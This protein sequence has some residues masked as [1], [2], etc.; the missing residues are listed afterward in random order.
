MILTSTEGQT[1]LPRYFSQAFAMGQG[2]EFGRLDIHLPD[3]RVFR[4]E[5]EKPGP[6]AEMHVHNADIF[7]RLIRDGDLGFSDGYLDEW[8]STP[9]LQ[10]FM[11]F[12]HKGNETI[13]DGFPGMALVRAYEQMRF[14]LQRNHKSQAKKNIA[15][16][17]DLGNDFYS[18]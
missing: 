3:A 9:D 4:I 2:I 10:A 16:H 17:Y 7:A 1:G 5:G 14:W 8:W 11:D 13:Y 15:Y 6:V 18:T 12:V